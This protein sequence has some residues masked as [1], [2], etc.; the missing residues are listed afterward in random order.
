MQNSSFTLKIPLMY[1][2][3]KYSPLPK[4]LINWTEFF[5]IKV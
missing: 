4:T 1:L 2:L 5:L 3:V